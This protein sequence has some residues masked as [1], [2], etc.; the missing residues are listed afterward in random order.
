MIREPSTPRENWR[1]RCEAVGFGFHSIDGIY[2]DETARYRFT[3]TQIET[4]EKASAECYRICME[5]ATHIIEKERFA[6]LAIPESAWALIRESWEADAPSLFGRFDFAWT[7]VG[8]P[9]LLEFNADTP[10]GLVEASV[11]QWHWL[12][13]MLPQLGANADQFNS[14]HEKLIAQWQWMRSENF[15]PQRLHFTCVG[16]HEEDE[17]NLDYLRDTAMQAGIEALPIAVENIG[18]REDGVFVDET[19]APIE[20]LFKLYPWEW[21]LGDTFGD[22]LRRTR[23]RI[24]EPAWKMVLANK[25]LLPILWELFPNHPNLLKASFNALDIVGDVVKKPLLSREGGNVE[26]TVSGQKIS[27]D[28]D[29][30]AE[31]FVYQQYAP[32]PCYD[33]HYATVGAWIVGDEPA[34]IGVREDATPITMNTSQ[35]VPHYFI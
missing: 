9:K 17:G 34:G 25:G 23:M 20:A 8:E 7:G 6:E 22:N 28:G 18:W 10:T 15:I 19:D 12:E 11:A 13:D 5:A 2:W 1:E 16:D 31:G 30:G 32:I 4:L 33:G 14:L 27:A 29:Y 3:A 26:M 35:F 21:M 24:I